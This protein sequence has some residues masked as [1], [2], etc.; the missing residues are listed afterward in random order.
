MIRLLEG[1]LARMTQ[2]VP[3][4]HIEQIPAIMQE[5]VVGIPP[6]WIHLMKR[7][8]RAVLVYI[9]AAE[10]AAAEEAEKA[11]E[12]DDQDDQGGQD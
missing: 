2:R 5:L 3:T 10:A 4:L 11:R 6:T 9:D 12:Q 7:V 8:A 1:K